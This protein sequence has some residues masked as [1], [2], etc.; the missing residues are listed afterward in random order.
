LMPSQGWFHHGA[1]LPTPGMSW[2]PDGLL[3]LPSLHGGPVLFAGSRPTPVDNQ[4]VV[5]RDDGAAHIPVVIEWALSNGL[6]RNP[7]LHLVWQGDEMRQQQISA[8]VTKFGATLTLHP[9][10]SV[11]PGESEIPEHLANA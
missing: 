10:T 8:I 11:K 6:W 7:K 3:R 5:I 2:G 1:D 9:T 4:Q